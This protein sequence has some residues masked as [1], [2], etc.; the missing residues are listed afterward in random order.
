MLGT[1]IFSL[2]RRN[3][4]G[5]TDQCGDGESCWADAIGLEWSDEQMSEWSFSM[6]IMI[7]VHR[8]GTERN[9]AQRVVSRV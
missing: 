4:S 9:V 1:Y 8:T 2:K 6:S 7:V 5:L 3:F